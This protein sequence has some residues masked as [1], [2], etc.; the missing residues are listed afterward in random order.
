[1][2]CSNGSFDKIPSCQPPPLMCTL[3]NVTNA[4][5]LTAAPNAP[6]VFKPIGRPL[7]SLDVV[8]RMFDWAVE[9]EVIDRA[10][11]LHSTISQH[12]AHGDNQYP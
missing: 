10:Q 3:P 11:P 4:V 7:D 1:M 8:P 12:S 2:M 5:G 6:L 9:S